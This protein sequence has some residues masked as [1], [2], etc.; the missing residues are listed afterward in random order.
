MKTKEELN[1]LRE[2]VEALNARLTELSDE[3]LKQVTGGFKGKFKYVLGT[4]D[5]LFGDDELK[6]KIIGREGRNGGAEE[7]R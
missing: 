5:A 7:Y 1:T 4:W 3:E 2:E 6:G